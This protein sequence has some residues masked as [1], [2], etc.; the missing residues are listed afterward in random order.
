MA[1]EQRAVTG[2]TKAETAKVLGVSMST[3]NRLIAAGHLTVVPA[4][5]I[6]RSSTYVRVTD[7]SIAA[8]AQQYRRDKPGKGK[9]TRLTAP[10]ST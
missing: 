1:D 7:E 6:G 8:V 3:I 4:L 10:D 5:R 2:M 9:R